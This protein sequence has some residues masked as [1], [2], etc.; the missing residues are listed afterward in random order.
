MLT[1]CVL[2]TCSHICLLLLFDIS[3]LLSDHFK[4][5]QAHLSVYICT[6]VYVCTC[7]SISICIE[8]CMNIIYI[9]VYVCVH[10]QSLQS[11]L[12]LCDPMDCSLPGSSVLGILQARIVE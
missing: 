10:A 8:I 5:L 11:C 3:L 6:C 9:Y 4:V 12:T 2:C 7:V 1:F